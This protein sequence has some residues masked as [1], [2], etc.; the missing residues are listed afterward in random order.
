[1]KK[2]ISLILSLSLALSLSVSALAATG[3]SFS[4]VPMSH[5]AY[6]YVEHAADEGW[7]AGVGGGKFNPDG[8]VTGAQ[9]YTMVARVFYGDQIPDKADTGKWYSDK[10]YGPYMQVGV[11]NMFDAYFAADIDAAVAERPMTRTEMACV[12]T[13]VMDQMGVEVPQ[14]TFY[15][16]ADTIPDLDK[17]PV[18]SSAYTAV[19]RCYAMGIIGGVDK[20]GTFNGDG[21]MNRAQAAVVLGRMA[22]LVDNGGKIPD[23]PEQPTETT[24]P[25]EPEQ[26]SEPTKPAT[27]SD[28]PTEQE[29]YNAIIALKAQYPDGTPWGDDKLYQIWA[30]IS[31]GE[32]Y[33][34]N[35]YGCAAFTQMCQDAAFGD[36]GTGKFAKVTHYDSFDDIRVGDIVRYDGHE[37]IVLKKKP[38]SI[39]VA[40]GNFNNA[41]YWGREIFKSEN[42]ESYK[43]FSISSRYPA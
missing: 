11:D 13:E 37:V 10:W 2:L 27:P 43:D 17:I 41:V 8:Q 21:L 23:A 35:C 39:I 26:P 6:Q 5:W 36:A 32:L 15:A 42:L 24:K 30:P 29:V 3:S 1:M 34:I 16:V 25:T 9:W 19:V 20:A 40:E 31:T 22:D 38:N 33:P 18:T 14:D 4:D 28:V 7:V 12:V